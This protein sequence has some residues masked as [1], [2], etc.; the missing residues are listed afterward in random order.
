VLA[1]IVA[2]VFVVVLLQSDPAFTAYLDGTR[3]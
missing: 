3:K 1:T 2:L